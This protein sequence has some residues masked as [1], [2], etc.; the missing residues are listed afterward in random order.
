MKT[1]HLSLIAIVIIAIIGTIAFVMILDVRHTLPAIT[2]TK[3]G[4]V[5]LHSYA[6][7]I[8]PK[9][10]TWI[11]VSRIE[12]NQ[13]T[14]ACTYLD[15]NML[16]KIPYL[17]EALVGADGCMDK[18]EICQVSRGMSISHDYGF[19]ISVDD[20]QDY[21]HSLT[22][23]DAKLLVKEVNL[24]FDGYIYYGTVIIDGKYYLVVLQT[25][26][27]S[28]DAQAET[29]PVP[30]DVVGTLDY[31][32]Y[33][34]PGHFAYCE[35][36]TLIVDG[37]EKTN[38]GNITSNIFTL[39]KKID[40]LPNDAVVIEDPFNKLTEDIKGKK[41]HVAGSL[42]KEFS[43]ECVKWNWNESGQQVI[44]SE[45]EPNPVIVAKI[46]DVLE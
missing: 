12:G 45:K 30:I 28:A 29:Y 34:T 2:N 14:Q 11:S 9:Q 25:S 46:I 21:E 40:V 17:S 8:V 23:E 38:L 22:P 7:D 35:H 44:S 24:S 13:T 19:G 26:D 37:M 27:E 16:Q 32:R 15:E 4:C 6:D 20:S 31:E 1:L 42:F 33:K 43:T 18:T 5:V 3:T 41:V 10:R 36:F 39:Y